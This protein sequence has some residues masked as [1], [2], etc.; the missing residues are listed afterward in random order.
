MNSLALILT[1][2][3]TGAATSAKLIANDAIKDAYDGLKR[4]IK[5]K[6]MGKPS[7]E[8]AL[9]EHEKDPETWEAPLKKALLQAHLDQDNDI[10]EAA[11]EVMTRVNPQ[12]AAL[13]KYNVQITG[14]IQGFAQGEQVIQ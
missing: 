10:I 8:M 9:I 4:R 13:S 2:L 7:A 3:D 12:Q 14:S 6:F 5:Y 11:Q 1:A